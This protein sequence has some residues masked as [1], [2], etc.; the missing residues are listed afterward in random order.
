MNIELRNQ[1]IAFL[2]DQGIYQHDAEVAAEQCAFDVAIGAVTGAAIPILAALATRIPWVAGAYPYT[3]AAGAF[4]A[5]AESPSCD[6]LRAA[7]SQMV[8]DVMR[9]RRPRR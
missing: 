7:V 1:L 8:E 4:V 3:A 2:T 9:G 5:L 6:Q